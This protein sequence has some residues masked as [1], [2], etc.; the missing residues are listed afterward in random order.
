MQIHNHILL[1]LGQY[2]DWVLDW[3]SD[4]AL[5][6]HWLVSVHIYIQGQS[7]KVWISFQVGLDR[8]RATNSIVLM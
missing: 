7:E 6:I 8:V 1:I 2:S 4:P 5:W 3:G